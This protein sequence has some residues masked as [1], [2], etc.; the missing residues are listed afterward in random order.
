MELLGHRRLDAAR[1]IPAEVV[2]GIHSSDNL[3]QRAAG[4]ASLHIPEVEIS[5][6]KH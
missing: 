4:W 1:E 6:A 3:Q 5:E 2:R